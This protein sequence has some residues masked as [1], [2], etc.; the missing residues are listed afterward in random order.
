MRRILTDRPALWERLDDESA[1]S[2]A[3]HLW[4]NP[5]NGHFMPS[6]KRRF[7][8]VLLLLIGGPRSA[9]LSAEVPAGGEEPAVPSTEAAPAATAEDVPS[10]SLMNHVKVVREQDRRITWYSPSFPPYSDFDFRVFPVIGLSDEGSRKIVL[11]IVVKDPPK[12]E[13][14]ALRALLDGEP[15]TVPIAESPGVRTTSSGCRT[16]Q[17]VLLQNQESLIQKVAAAGEIQVS[18]EGYRR[19]AHY[20]LTEEDRQNFRR[21]LELWRMK[22]LPAAPGEAPKQGSASG[23][24]YAGLGGVTNPEILHKVPPRFPRIAEGKNVLGRVV[25]QA[26]VRKDGSVGDLEVLQEAGGD[27]GF[28]EAALEAI[29]QWRYKPATKGGEPVDAYFTIV[30]DFTYPG[31]RMA[32]F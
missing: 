32:P 19:S 25:L 31:F 21:I 17:V 8:L 20:R 18:I 24:S 29:R 6:H 10:K 30:V 4:H 9:G 11:Q 15:W 7:L 27:C 5:P 2:A 1:R 3:M 22:T 13:P 26:I 12:G 28:E 23:V 16:T 14:R